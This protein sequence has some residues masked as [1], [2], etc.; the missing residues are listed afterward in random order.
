MNYAD[1]IT[2]TRRTVSQVEQDRDI[3]EECESNRGRIINSAAI[4]RLQQKTQVFPL[5][6]NAAV[7]SRLT[8]SMEVMQT[9][10]YIARTILKK[11]EPGQADGLDTAFVTT[12][13]MACLMHDIGNPPFGHF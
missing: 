10:R 12:V 5:E 1:K 7:R 9:G 2:P 11:L 8:H 13:E 6:T 4:R 3:T